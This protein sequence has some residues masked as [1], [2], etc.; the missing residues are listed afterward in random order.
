M[1]TQRPRRVEPDMFE[2]VPV[3]LLFADATGR[4][5]AANPAWCTLTGQGSDAWRDHGWMRAGPAD[6]LPAIVSSRAPY[7]ADW[8]V[9]NESG[10]PTTLRVQIVPDD[11]RGSGIIVSA[12][13]VTIEREQASHLLKRATH[14]PLTGLVNRLQFMEFL[15]HSLGRRHREG[16]LTAVFFID[17]DNFKATNDTYGHHAGDRLLR[18]L[19]THIS[20]S[21]RPADVVS[22]YGGDEFTVLCE[23]LGG[24][25]E[26]RAIA[27]RI[28][29]TVSGVAGHHEPCSLSVGYALVE[30]PT[31][32][33]MAIVDLAD[34][35]MYLEKQ[36]RATRAHRP[37]RN[38]QP[39]RSPANAPANR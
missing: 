5:T 11:G 15:G 18:E 13:D 24:P 16:S 36:R 23:D 9:T 25:D 32:D 27:E 26:A 14:D 1:D 38:T 39:S 12:V 34:R 35:M 8:R 31:L 19:A 30:D 6:V 4:A 21:V 28:Q 29:H 3:G 22:R 10:A 2:R 17:V 20:G 7:Q 33:P 37:N